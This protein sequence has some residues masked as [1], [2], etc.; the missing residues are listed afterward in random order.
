LQ[1]GTFDVSLFVS[2][3]LGQDSIF[4]T[5]VVSVNF[6]PSPISYNDTSYVSPATFQL[7][8]ATSSVNWYIDTL[9]TSSIFSGSPFVTPMLNANT[10]YYVR[11]IGGPTIFG[12]PVDNTIGNGGYYNND[13]HLFLDCYSPSTLISTDVYAGVAQAITFELRDNNSQV[14]ADTT[15][16]VQVGLNTL[17]LYF[18]V[19]VMN[20]LELGMN[21]GYSDL[22][23]NSTGSAYPYLIGDI[24][25]I[26]GHNSP[27]SVS[28]H[29]FFYNLKM[30]ENC[31]SNFAEATAV[32]MLPTLVEDVVKSNFLIYPNPATNSINISTNESIDRIDIYDVKGRLIFTQ[33]DQKKSTS[34]H[35]SNF[36][37]GVY[38]V[39]V[40]S[41]ENSSVQQL[42]IE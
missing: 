4:Q 24:A 15:I 13:R 36:A 41:K 40:V 12:G 22:Y 33:S 31:I 11:E 1:A 19:P 25:S 2:N 9:G 17:Y 6:T 28:Y 32:F 21:T 18:D 3:G 35:V 23:R 20:D 5:S 14:L 42:I 29:Y 37:K 16:T 8:T 34:I 7:T 38:T 30:K 26:T 27:N 10:T 39:K